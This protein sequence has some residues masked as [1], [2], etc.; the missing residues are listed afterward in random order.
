MFL[1]DYLLAC[2]IST[3]RTQTLKYS[4]SIRFRSPG[5]HMAI[6]KRTYLMDKHIFLGVIPAKQPSSLINMSHNI[7]MKKKTACKH[8]AT[9]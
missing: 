5:L 1:G 7:N 6:E 8:K 3:V 2:E 9:V 4:G